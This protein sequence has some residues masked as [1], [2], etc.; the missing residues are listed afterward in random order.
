MWSHEELPQVLTRPA[1]ESKYKLALSVHLPGR[2]ASEG[3]LSLL[4]ECGTCLCYQLLGAYV[5]RRALCRRLISGDRPVPEEGVEPYQTMFFP[6]GGFFGTSTFSHFF[7]PPWESR[8][9]THK[10]KGNDGGLK[11][12]PRGNRFLIK[13]SGIV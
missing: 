7:Q 12:A 6:G 13:Q 1:T 10:Q 4:I 9:V 5:P 3:F 8:K 2:I 11:P